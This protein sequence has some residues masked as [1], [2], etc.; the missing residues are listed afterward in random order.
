MTKEEWLASTDL[1]SMLRFARTFADEPSF[2]LFA[3]ACCWRIWG[4]IVDERSRRAVEVAERFARGLAS[5]PDLDF[6][7]DLAEDALEEAARAEYAAE[8]LAEFRYTA[9]YCEVNA[10]LYAA[11]AARQA[12]SA[13]ASNMDDHRHFGQE[14]SHYW[15]AAAQRNDA[16]SSV[17]DHFADRTSGTVD[18][19]V[20]A[21]GRIAVEEEKEAQASI[22]RDLIQLPPQEARRVRRDQ[23]SGTTG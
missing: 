15:A 5:R 21:A 18:D 10:R 12:T 14:G 17:Y 22:L 7:R 11:C 1:D 23:S 6:A 3:C 2:R 4:R 20:A 19:M 9:R 8:A 16:M 13:S